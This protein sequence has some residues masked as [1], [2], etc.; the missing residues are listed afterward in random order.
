MYDSQQHMY[1]SVAHEL[2]DWIVSERKELANRLL[3]GGRSPF[4][5]KTSESEKLA[6]YKT[7]YFLDDGSPNEQGRQ[8][9]L[10][11]VGPQNFALIYGSLKKAG[12][13]TMPDSITTQP[14]VDLE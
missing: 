11:R 12:L 7:Q 13:P 8:Q 6:Y 2:S 14:E 3:A 9:T 10:E 1:E 4:A 5:A